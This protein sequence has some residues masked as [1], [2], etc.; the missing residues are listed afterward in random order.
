MFIASKYEEMYAPE[1]G[2]FVQITDRIYRSIL[3]TFANG[4]TYSVQTGF[5][6]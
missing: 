6:T 2:D 5:E 4:Q 3:E 1:I